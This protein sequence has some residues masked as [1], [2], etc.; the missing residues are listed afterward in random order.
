M[1]DDATPPRLFSESRSFWKSRI[2]IRNDALAIIGAVQV[3]SVEQ[4]FPT[5]ESLQRRH[6]ATDPGWIND[7]L[8]DDVDPCQPL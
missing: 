1:I 5:L 3:D 7:W 8:A 6:H 2:I 4:D